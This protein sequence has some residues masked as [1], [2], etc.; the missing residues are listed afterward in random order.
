MT[1]TADARP[2]AVNTEQG[3]W[4]CDERVEVVLASVGMAIW[5]WNLETGEIARSGG[6]AALFGLEDGAVTGDPD[7]YVARIHPDDRHLLTEMDRRHLEDGA[8]YEVEY[9]VVRPDGSLSWLREKAQSVRDAGGRPVRLLGVTM[10]VTTRKE[11]EEALSRSDAA[12][13]T[14]LAQIPA[15]TYVQDAEDPSRL[16]YVNPRVESILGYSADEW[17]TPTEPWSDHLHPDDRERVLTEIARTERTGE[18]FRMEYRE[19]TRDGRYVW[20]QDEAVLVRDENGTPLCW[21]GVK[22][23][24]TDR[25]ETEEV[26]RRS[27]ARFRSLITHATDIITILDADGTI[28]YKSPPTKRILG[29]DHNELVGRNVFDL[30]HPDDRAATRTAFEDA[31][32]D[33][34][35]APTVAFR[36]RH[37][38]GSWRWLESTGTNL[39]ADRDVGGFVVNS[40]DVT[41]RKETEQRLRH[42]EARF[43]AL[44]E[45]VSDMISILDADGIRT[46][47]SPAYEHILGYPP[48]ELL[49][50]HA[51]TIDHPDD[52]PLAR[53]FFAEL[54]QRPGAVD[55]LEARVRHHDGSERWLEVVAT[56]RLDDPDV[57]GIVI[58]SRDVT[59]R[60]AL[61][62]RLRH[63]AHHDPLTALP[64][65]TLFLERLGQALDRARRRRSRPSSVPI[66]F[67]DL[68]GF[69][70]VNDSLG[71]ATGDRLLVAAANRLASALRAGDLLARFGGDEFAVLVEHAITSDEAVRMAQRLLT[72]LE[73]PVALDGYE[74]VVSASIGVAVSSLD[75]SEPGDVLRAA[76]IA[77]YRAKAIGKGSI[78][79]FD[80]GADQ[81]ALGRLERETAL[82]HAVEREELRIAY[83][84]VIH[85]ATGAVAGVEALVRWERPGCGLLLPEEFVPLAEETGLIVPI[86]TWM[87]AEACRAIR[88]WRERYPSDPPLRLNLNLSLPEFR[89]P[90]L[91]RDLACL[92]K[93]TD[94]PPDGL[95]LELTE[96]VATTDPEAARATLRDVT[97]LGVRLAIDDFGTGYASLS[98]LKRFPVDE[99]KV[100]RSFVAG[101]GQQQED[102]AIVRATIGVAK[103]LGL[104]VTAE[105]VETADQVER[106]RELGCDW[107]QGFFFAPPLA[108]ADLDA[109]LKA[110]M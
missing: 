17:S 99:L 15:I 77:L 108:A 81:P 45:H 26:L 93:A 69:K 73:P 97:A 85:L 83:Q 59:D 30:I 105:G 57:G 44:V 75:L 33:P 18:P 86:G 39:M 62:G 106:L 104:R 70:V 37:Q 76:D 79:I 42:S 36:F 35:L 40:R 94:L 110:R 5:D 52:A 101:L 19:R 14:L 65:R 80:P 92:L 100:D 47:A 102:T 90:T 41:D 1:G 23:E 72:T 28:R 60:K 46:Y 27:E 91:S 20:F 31:L 87:R 6:M 34:A 25:K 16:L 74:A 9:R 56:N 51:T 8:D 49:G 13:R 98:A 12:Y 61:E 43:R 68:D 88:A 22:L 64:N 21:Q 54:A 55:R 50:R 103:A 24:I 53:A 96:T 95:T 78:A 2:A 32:V 3:P 29:Y 66:L 11:A 4:E 109:F 89:Q 10:D 58:N 38:D 71:H 7:A 48:S 84:P 63:Q 82:R 67:L 107:G